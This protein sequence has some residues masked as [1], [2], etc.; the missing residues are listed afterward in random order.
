MPEENLAGLGV[1]LQDFGDLSGIVWNRRTGQLVAGHQRVK[2]LRAAGVKDWTLDGDAGAV[3]HPKTRERFPVRVV[4]WDEI[5]QRAANITANNP[6]I[7]GEW[8]VQAVLR[9]MKEIEAKLPDFDKL[10]LARLEAALA[11]EYQEAAG[12]AVGEAKDTDDEVPEPP[13]VPVTK[14]GDLWL[15]GK[16][17]L[18][19]GETRDDAVLRRLIGS[20]KLVMEHADPPYGMGKEADGIENDNLYE[21]KLDAFQMEWWRAW[22]PFL[23]DIGSAYIWGNAPD[24]WRLWWRHLALAEGEKLLA[25]NEIVWDKGSGFGMRSAGAHSFPPATERCLFLMRGQQFLG[26]QNKEDFWEGYEP[27]RAW[28]EAERIKAGWSNTDVN[29]ITKT[30]M[31][32]HWF[33]QSQFIPIAREQYET[34]AA[35]AEGRAFVEPYDDLFERM[36]PGAKHGGNQHRRDLAAKLREERTYFDNTHDS[37]TD[38]WQFP[39][40]VG[41]E[42]FGHATPK[43]VAMVLRAM[44]S[45]SSE[46]D[47]VGVPFA[48]TGPEF[49]A[50]E[51][52]ERWALGAEISPAYCDIIVERWEQRT[53]GKAKRG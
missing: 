50:G 38:V 11:A 52:G 29:K 23:S 20:R 43:P 35:A 44:L 31:A 12:A 37:M 21:E 14:P 30:Q 18:I 8:D 17:R 47:F 36:F 40:V 1:S 42:R 46:G 9:Q 22:L 27:L 2:A 39:R 3:V 34:I 32:G 25:R 45:S 6:Q 51:R 49:I 24:L 48:G 41:E 16:Q 13:K 26:N 33:S 5:T 10:G 28:L 4:D 7:S 19:C 53:G 15:L